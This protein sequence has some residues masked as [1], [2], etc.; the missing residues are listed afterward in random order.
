MEPWMLP[1]VEKLVGQHLQ[2]LLDAQG[3]DAE[4]G[5]GVPRGWTPTSRPHVQ[6]SLDGT[7]HNDHPIAAYCSVRF[8]ARADGIAAVK[9]LA[10]QCEALLLAHS[11]AEVPRSKTLIGP[12]PS[13]D[14]E[15][16]HDMC[17][18]TLRV[19]VRLVPLPA[20]TPAP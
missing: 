10:A 17:W 4:V 18:F 15:T 5:I 13:R 12:M 16:G 14:P 8:V 19:T 11:T 3:I 7:P 1:D 6:V 9:A 20:P 2:T